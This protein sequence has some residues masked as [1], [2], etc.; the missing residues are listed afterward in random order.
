MGRAAD[1]VFQSVAIQE[2][3]DDG[4][5]LIGNIYVVNGA[6][7]WMIE[8][9]CG[10]GFTLEA[11]ERTCCVGSEMVRQELE[12]DVALQLVGSTISHCHVLRKLGGGGMGV[13]YE[14]EELESS[15][16]TA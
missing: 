6:D 7:I 8:S 4:R 14:A 16:V 11:A 2:L 3:H 10:L 12:R 9:R 5:L 13:V 1:L 15:G